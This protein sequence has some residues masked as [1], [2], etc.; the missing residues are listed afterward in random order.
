MSRRFAWLAPILLV[1]LTCALYAGAGSHSR[2]SEDDQV[3]WQN[4]A[5]SGK[6]AGEALRGR[7]FDTRSEFRP[8][9][10]PLAAMVL[11]AE[12]AVFSYERRGFQ[13][14]LILLHAA[15]AVLVWA[16][17][18]RLGSN[19]VAA[20]LGGAIFA[21]HPAAS[22]TVLRLAGTSDA[23][24]LLF[25]LS[26]LLVVDSLPV[27]KTAP[28]PWSKLIAIGLL[29]LAA[30]LSKEAAFAFAPA[31]IAWHLLPSN[32]EAGPHP[33]RQ[34]RTIQLL[35]TVGGAVVVALLWRV[36]SLSSLPEHLRSAVATDATSG[37]PFF[38]RL[39]AALA[40]IA[41]YW[42]LLLFPWQLGYAYD[43][44]F[45]VKGLHLWA[46]VLIGIATLAVSA[47]GIPLLIR[48]RDRLALPLV[49]L[50]CPLIAALGIVAPMGDFASERMLYFVIPGF[51]AVVITGAT[52]LARGKGPPAL[53]GAGWVFG[54]LIIMLFAVRTFFRTEDY[55]DRESYVKA[56]VATY[57]ESAT[58]L[59]DLGNY[60]LEQ[61]LW[62]GARAWYEKA[63]AT[64]EDFWP[65][66][67]NLGASYFSEKEVGLARRAYER[68][69]QGIGNQKAFLVV[70][71]KLQFNRAIVLMQQDQNAEAIPALLETV[72]VFPNHLRAHASLGFIFSNS[73]KF[74][75]QAKHHLIRAVDLQTDPDL[76]GGLLERLE[77]VEKRHRL[78]LERQ[79][80]DAES[81]P[82]PPESPMPTN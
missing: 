15:N 39:P 53:I 57:P 17:L 20:S 49:L 52:A 75:E 71:A 6:T 16:L 5:A 50:V 65:A 28:S 21:V 26:A 44:L 51:L 14:I 58:G 13:W 73:D 27:E 30:C 64:R 74:Y 12:H 18:R 66:W 32:N 61:G 69:L 48:R 43:W 62:P 46:P 80:L 60:Y 40:A 31:L 4:P 82:D 8:I 34:R 56:Q 77:F 3:V 54:A 70:R 36:L 42:R 55:R 67:V 59:Y 23:L 33:A 10:R 79:Q 35:S 37:V 1:I 63:I 78:A 19:V 68:A 11:R 7:F 45:V 22:A 38:A 24:A 29:M 9:V 25:V 72:A 76:V 2:L 47:A 41:I 81:E